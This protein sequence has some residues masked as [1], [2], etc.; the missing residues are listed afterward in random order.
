[1]L[2]LKCIKRNLDNKKKFGDFATFSYTK[3]CKECKAKINDH[4]WFRMRE[5]QRI[6]KQE[7]HHMKSIISSSWDLG[8]TNANQI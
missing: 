5:V 8:N 6:E 4:K 7:S 1:M 2:C 3:I